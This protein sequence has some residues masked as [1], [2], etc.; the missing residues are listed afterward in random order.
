MPKFVRLAKLTEQGVKNL[1][2]FKQMVAEA[3]AVMKNHGIT[4][5]AAY[6]TMGSYD[7]VAVIDAPDIQTAA[8]A[9]ALIAQ[10]GNFRAE[11]LAAIP[12]REFVDLVES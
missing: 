8:K 1:K 9:S 3:Q 7:I 4:L 6:A 11:S 5:E 10:Q 12:L 2:G